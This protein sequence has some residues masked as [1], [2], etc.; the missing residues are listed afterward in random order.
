MKKNNVLIAGC[1]DVG[2]ALGLALLKQ[3]RFNVWG[4]RRN[5][6]RLPAGI[7]P[8]R[9]DL[10]S[11]SD[12]GDWPASIDYVVYCAAANERSEEG[13]HR[14]Y[15]QGLSH[16]LQRISGDNYHPARIFFTSSTSVYHQSSGEWVDETSETKP[17]SFAGQTMLKAEAVLQA[18]SFPTTT[19]RFG[20]IYG[21]GRSRLINRVKEGNG[22][23]SSPA[24][25]GNRI[26][27][28]DCAGILAH[29]IALD[30]QGQPVKP[31]Y[32]G[33]DHD[34]APVYDVLQWLASQLKVTLHNE[35]SPPA[36]GNRR[37]SNKKILVSGYRFIY[38][39]YR[40]GYRSLLCD[41]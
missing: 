33:V 6:D 22:C 29:L 16:V 41:S 37:C 27:R 35:G 8:V 4:L 24:V 20:G 36:R 34:P 31:L 12:L 30:L 26:H 2:S 32:L 28:D 39:D 1:G 11:A 15:T 40:Q 3:G 5:P 25:Y 9:G 7:Y 23:F 14:A 19:V 13:Y 38:P 17:H 10:E 18:A 21:P